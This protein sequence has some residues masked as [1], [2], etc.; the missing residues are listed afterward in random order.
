MVWNLGL[1]ETIVAHVLDGKIFQ[2]YKRAWFDICVY[3]SLCRRM[4][5]HS[6]IAVQ[7]FFKHNNLGLTLHTRGVSPFGFLGLTI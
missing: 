4:Y 6:I 2:E 7:Y 1:C 3:V 5:I